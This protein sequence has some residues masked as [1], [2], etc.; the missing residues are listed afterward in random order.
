MRSKH[1]VSTSIPMHRSFKATS[2]AICA[3]NSDVPSDE[4]TVTDTDKWSACKLTSEM[5][6]GDA[7]VVYNT[8]TSPAR[9]SCLDL[10]PVLYVRLYCMILG[11]ACLAYI[12]EWVYCCLSA[13]LSVHPS[14]LDSLHRPVLATPISRV[15]IIKSRSSLS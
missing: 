14:C 15:C 2:A 7:M 4:S 3:P 11:C 8:S 5:G 13:S 10:L 12:A 1:I 9:L 6:T